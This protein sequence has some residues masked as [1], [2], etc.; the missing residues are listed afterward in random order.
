MDS[1]EI[2]GLEVQE[3]GGEEGLVVM[4]TERLGPAPE[5]IPKQIRIVDSEIVGSKEIEPRRR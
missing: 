2:V 1:K 5:M 3:R 4:G